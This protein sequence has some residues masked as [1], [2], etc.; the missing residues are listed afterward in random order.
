MGKIFAGF[1]VEHVLT[2]SV[3]D[4]AIA[5]DAT[6]GLDPG[7]P[8]GLPEPNGSFAASV[9]QDP[10]TLRIAYSLQPMMG[11]TIHPDCRIAVEQTSKLLCNLGHDVEEAKRFPID[12]ESFRY[13]YVC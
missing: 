4:S 9:D 11:A 5:L 7:A 10:G 13:A 2:K 6:H 1:G 3:R 12:F 8:Y